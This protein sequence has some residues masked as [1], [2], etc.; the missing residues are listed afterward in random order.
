MRAEK[1]GSIWA[2]DVGGKWNAKNTAI[3]ATRSRGSTTV[4]LNV[5]KGPWTA[6][7]LDID[8]SLLDLKA[9]VAWMETE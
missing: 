7:R 3:K 1:T 4:T 9:L 6:D 5:P 2:N 8:V